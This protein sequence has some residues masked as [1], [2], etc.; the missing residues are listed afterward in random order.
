MSVPYIC[1]FTVELEGKVVEAVSTADA[2]QKSLDGE[3]AERSALEAVAVSACEGLGA[4]VGPLGSS[5]WWRI[6]A[7]YS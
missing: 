3:A 2:L 7:L 5:L 1:P 6:E 4:E